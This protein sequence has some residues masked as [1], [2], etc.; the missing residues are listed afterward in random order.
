MGEQ[1]QPLDHA[2]YA[3]GDVTRFLLAAAAACVVSAPVP[4]PIGSGRAYRLPAAPAAVRAGEPVGRFHC[5]R[6]ESPRVLAHV[7]LFARKQALLLPPGIGM[8][9]PLERAGASVRRARCSYAVRTTG[10]TG[11]VESLPA[12]QAT[13]GDLFAIWGRPLSPRRLAGFTGKVRAWVAGC[14]WAGDVRRIPLTRR[15][16]I[17]VEIGG[18]VPPHS[19]FLFPIRQADR[20]AGR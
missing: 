6:A 13:L 10:P 14:P 3:N 15:A 1:A 12:A 5:L 20:P 16:Q 18:Y 7:E 4:T 9:P 2:P 19:T 17:V 8:A 11:V